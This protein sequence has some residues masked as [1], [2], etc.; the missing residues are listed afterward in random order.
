MHHCQVFCNIILNFK[1]FID[2]VKYMEF[3]KV[4]NVKMRPIHK[5]R[6]RAQILFLCYVSFFTILLTISKGITV[7]ANVSDNTSSP[8]FNGTHLNTSPPK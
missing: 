2:V 7:K 5:T 1:L 8:M 6:C 3:P 4:D